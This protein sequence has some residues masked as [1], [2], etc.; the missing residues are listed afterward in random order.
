MRRLG[1]VLL[2]AALLRV[3]LHLVWQPE[4]VGDAADYD[5]LARG[6][7]AGRG[8][9]DADGDP[10]SFRPPLYPLL[11]ALWY[12]PLSAGPRAA[13]LFQIGLDLAAVAVTYSLARR[14]LAERFALV[15]SGLV[16]VNVA[17]ISAS[18][19]LLSE[20]L[21][22]LLLVLSAWLTVRWLDA[23]RDG[24][25]C[26][27]R[28]AA[29]GATLGLATLTRGVLLPFV[30]LLILVAALSGRRL[31]RGSLT[32]LAVFLLTLAPWTIRNARVHG[33][34]V[35]VT[36]QVG[37]TLYAGFAPPGGV[38]GLQPQ[39][40]A[41]QRVEHLPEAEQSRALTREALRVAAAD[42]VRTAGL[43]LRKAV[44]F[45]SPVDWEILPRYGTF[46]PTYAWTAALA[47]A[48]LLLASGPVPRRRD[49][50]PVWLPVLFLFAMALVF[51][52][53]P[54]YRLPAEPLLAVLAG[55]GVRAWTH[56]WGRRASVASLAGLAALCL[57]AT[58][59]SDP[60]RAWAGTWVR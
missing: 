2:T 31:P 29:L 7:A 44:Y 17:M 46:N 19:R 5:R 16:A 26:G 51:H 12:G 48:A 42:P 50:W 23:A 35:P 41:V 9:L 15:A 3:A 1:V 33:A 11:L 54:R 56:R 52:G 32:L 38:F 30:P 59:F 43:E 20:S 49:L 34:L 24:D 58:A 45:W 14:W 25:P 47:I 13:T 57:L 21:F 18:A 4:L 10:T 27:G 6:L 40:S 8:M 60:L 37:I 36:T 53:S 28:A 39:D 22:T 55:L